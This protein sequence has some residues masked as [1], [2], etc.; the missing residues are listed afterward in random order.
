MLNLNILSEGG[1]LDSPKS[2]Y[3]TDFTNGVKHINAGG[4]HEDNPY[5]GIQMGMDEMG[6][7]NL[8]EEGEV[9]FNDYVFSNRL[10]PTKEDLGIYKLPEK[11]DG[12]TFAEI[13]KKVSEESEERPNDPISMRGLNASMA[14]L[15]QA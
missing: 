15:V 9:V 7:P 3:G 11:Y 2:S 12:L 8:V 4:S 6:I 14:K 13:A 1:N 10:N 5:E